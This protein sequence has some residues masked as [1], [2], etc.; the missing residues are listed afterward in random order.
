MIKMCMNLIRLHTFL[1]FFLLVCTSGYAQYYPTNYFQAPMDTPLYLSAPFGSLRDNHFHSGMDIRTYEK[2]GLPVYAVADGYVSRI[3]VSPIGY[4]K[5]IYIDHTNGYTSV[6]GHLQRYVGDIAAYVKN[7][8]YEKESFD[9]DHFPGRDR[10][11][12]KKGQLIGWSGNSG[13]STGPHLHFEIRNT[14]SEEP[15]NPLL[16]GIPIADQYAPLIKKIV[17]YNLDANR[18]QLLNDFPVN[19][20]KLIN[21]DSVWYYR[22]TLE[23][24]KGLTGFGADAFDYMNNL[25][26]EYSLYGMEL[27]ID[28]QQYFGYRID[29]I[30]FENSRCINTHIDYEIYKREQVRIQKCF[31]DDG[32][33]IKI[34]NFMHNKGKYKLTDDNIHKVT[35]SVCDFDGRTFSLC[36]YIK[37]VT[38]DALRSINIPLCSSALFYPKKDNTFKA[39][40]ILLEVPANALYD[41]LNFCYELK[42]KERNTFSATHKIHDQY[43]PLHK[44][45]TISIKPENYP[46]KLESKLLLAY[47]VRDGNIRSAGG[48]FNNGYVTARN[49]NFGNYFVTMDTSAPTIAPLNIAK[50]GNIKDTLGIRIKVQDDFSGIASYKA[51]LD[52]KWILLDYDAKNDLLLYEFDENTLKGIKQ[53]L[54]ITVSDRKNNTTIYAKEIM[55][56]SKA[57]Q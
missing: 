29:R 18:P 14:R 25:S 23:I 22:D 9:F 2:E 28:D 6:Y 4:G 36:F 43:T 46:E 30:D 12:V 7:Y 34:Y 11:S 49:N 24:A 20:T 8:Q 10:L 3:K 48:E 52:G 45:F 27:F 33:K 17:I 19:F 35:L 38:N 40:D 16:F 21:I 31:L 55:I 1:V 15:L 51:T 13:G 54:I 53:Q 50:D 32:N 41:T 56:Y 44:S 42:G 5:A 26:H 37:G 47:Y 39:K 57:G